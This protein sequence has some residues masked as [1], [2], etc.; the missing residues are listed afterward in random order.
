KKKDLITLR[1]VIYQ[2]MQMA[3]LRGRLIS[4]SPI[5]YE[6]DLSKVDRANAAYEEQIAQEES[7]IMRNAI[8]TAHRNFLKEVVYL[9]YANNQLAEADRWFQRIREKYP[10]V[11]PPTQT[12]EQYALEKVLGNLADPSQDRTKAI[13]DGII[14]KHYLGLALDEDGQADGYDRM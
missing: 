9:F 7:E 8:K 10:G 6:P 1:R 5:W 11:F 14:L 3:V 2:S 13:L 12:A 4:V